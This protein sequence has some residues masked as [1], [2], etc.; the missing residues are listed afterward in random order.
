MTSP[1][2]LYEVIFQLSHSGYDLDQASAEPV[3]LFPCSALNKNRCSRRPKYGESGDRVIDNKV[4]TVQSIHLADSW[5][6]SG[7]YSKCKCLAFSVETS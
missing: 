7:S 4:Q 1:G 6:F 5:K 2:S 3:K